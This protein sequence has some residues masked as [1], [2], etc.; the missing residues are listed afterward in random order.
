MRIPLSWLNDYIAVSE[1][2]Q[3][4]VADALTMAG[5]EVEETLET[6]HGKVWY[7]KI[8]P[9]R[10]DWASVYG[11][12]RELAAIFPEKKLQPQHP[13]RSAG[14]GGGVSIRIDD[15]ANC[16]RFRATVIKNVKI[17]PTPQWIQDRLTA[18]LGDR[19]R[20]IN[21]VADIT[22][23]VMLELGQPLHA[24]DLDTIP[25]SEI[26]V[27]QSRVGE[28]LVTLDG[29]EHELPEGTLCICD[30]QRAI[31]IAGIM[32]G[33][34]TEITEGT[35]NVLLETAHFDPFCVRRTAKKVVRSEASYRFERYVDPNLVAIAGDRA[36]QLIVE[37]CGGEIVGV[38][39]AVAQP[40]P[41]RRFLARL[42]RVRVLLGVDVDRDA[43]IAALTRLGLEVEQSAGALDCLIPAWRPDLT[44]EDDIAEEVGRIALG[45]ANI[46]EKI[47]WQ[48]GQR[49]QD[50]P[51]AAFILR[52]KNALVQQGLQ[53]VITH[54]LVADGGPGALLLRNPMAPE[55]SQLRT[56]LV[57]NHI[58]IAQRAVREGIRDIA[59]FEVG[60]IYK[61]G[62]EPLR[63]SGL[64]SGSANANLW[65][66]KG[67]SYPA[68]FYYAKGI[69]E[70]LLAGLGIA[71]EYIADTS[72]FTH[73]YRTA[74]VLV[75]GQNI[76]MIGEFS[77]A[78]IE[79]NDLPKRTCVF[80]LDGEA[81]A[82]LAQETKV[83][84]SA[85][86]EFASATRD[87]APVFSKD[88]SYDKIEQAARASAGPLLESLRLADVFE[89]ASKLGEGKRSLTL[90]FTLRAPDRT[91][92][93]EEIEATLAGIRAAL[94]ALGA[95]RL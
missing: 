30:N 56:S 60:N 46:P 27:R 19:Y 29:T 59:I 61:P 63:V 52:L 45:Y 85:L 20:M 80:G 62:A 64:V 68:D 26:V 31:S 83:G 15:T 89:D 55:Y 6:P 4:A 43:A 18:A 44:I 13:P 70:S 78:V 39:E 1:G 17:G 58:G 54:S 38:S 36:A 65:A 51:R 49:G 95:E 35:T 14:A 72:P 86:P 47:A 32:G 37:H 3:E 84:F 74:S 23:Y 25:N 66:I 16:H 76:G 79:A 33:K 48:I 53:E 69:V 67:E 88:I 75:N 71:A 41:K 73:P 8:T 93:G 57:P 87:I 2:E 7:T 10:G 12:A 42:D 21:N 34:D 22:N 5:L 82:A 92:T 94:T 50:S 90:R 77:T 40:T 11:T 81:L 24:F 28:K 91:L 9:N